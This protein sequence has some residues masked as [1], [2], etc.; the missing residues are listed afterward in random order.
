MNQCE[1]QNP[2]VVLNEPLK[3]EI[4]IVVFALRLALA[5]I[6]SLLVQ[7]SIDDTPKVSQVGIGLLQSSLDVVNHVFPRSFSAQV[8]RIQFHNHRQ[9]DRGSHTFDQSGER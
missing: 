4:H 2:E 8:R 9:S 7:K 1:A 6:Q 5:S 3:A